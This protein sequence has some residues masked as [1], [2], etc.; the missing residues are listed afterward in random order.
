MNCSGSDGLTFRTEISETSLF[1]LLFFKAFKYKERIKNASVLRNHPTKEVLCY[2]EGFQKKIKKYLC[3]YDTLSDEFFFEGRKLLM[4]YF[5]QVY[6][7]GNN[8]MI[9]LAIDTSE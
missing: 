7:C 5:P 1:L 6:C 8:L 3:V 9:Y 2:C 4:P